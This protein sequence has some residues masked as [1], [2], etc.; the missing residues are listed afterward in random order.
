MVTG[1]RFSALVLSAMGSPNC[2]T[3]TV[4]TPR[5]VDHPRRFGGRRLRRGLSWVPGSETLA[6]LGAVRRV[7][8]DDA[9]EHGQH[10]EHSCQTGNTD[11]ADRRQLISNVVRR[12]RRDDRKRKT[13]PGR[14]GA[15]QRVRVG[16]V[17]VSLRGRQLDLPPKSPRS[18]PDH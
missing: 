11:R 10:R 18:R 1:R 7:R 6:A 14:L 3:I 8:D 5:Q 17:M 12:G 2:A 15:T 16:F 4:L 13:E 9:T